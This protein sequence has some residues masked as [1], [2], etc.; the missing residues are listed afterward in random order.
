MGIQSAGI[1]VSLDNTPHRESAITEPHKLQKEEGSL[2]SQLSCPPWAH[3]NGKDSAQ[4]REDTGQCCGRIGDGRVR[5]K[6]K[7]WVTVRFSGAIEGQEWKQRACLGWTTGD[8]CG[9]GV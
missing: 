4:A 9:V 1:S 3:R 7:H 8:D 6:A 5:S 2:G